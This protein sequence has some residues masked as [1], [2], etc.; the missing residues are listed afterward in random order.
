[1]HRVLVRTAVQA[2]VT[3]VALVLAVLA[4][5]LAWPGDPLG[6]FVRRGGPGSADAGSTVPTVLAVVV[7]LVVTVSPAAIVLLSR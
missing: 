1:M 5:V 2:V 4:A 3:T 7:G 6:S